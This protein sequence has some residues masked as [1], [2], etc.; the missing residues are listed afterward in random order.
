MA[1]SPKP[2]ILVIDD[3]PDEAHPLQIEVAK[4]ARLQVV[5]P[6]ELT[7]ELIQ[8]ANLV[9]VDFR[10]EDWQ[11]RENVGSL[12]LKPMNGLALAAV[13]RS[14]LHGKNDVSPTAFSIYSAHLD[15]LSSRLPPEPRA[16][17]IAGAHD[18]EW[19]FSKASAS[20]DVPLSQQV[21]SLAK[22]VQRLPPNWPTDGQKLVE[23]E[24]R[25]LFNLPGRV[26]WASRAWEDV[27]DCYPPIHELSKWSHGL[28][29]LRWM[30][31]RILPYPCFLMDSHSLA[32]RLRV[33]HESLSNALGR[34]G[35][36]AKL[37]EPALY[38]GVL[39]D[40]RGLRWWKSGVEAV[41]REA[42]KDKSV[43]P[44]AFLSVLP[45]HGADRLDP[46]NMLEPVNCLD[47]D[48]RV[49]PSTFSADLAVRIQPDDWP[50][51]A[52]QAWTTIELAKEDASLRALV[53]AQ[54]RNRI[55]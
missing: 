16:H 47:S 9:L 31:H 3:H 10:L 22:A 2:R 48:F 11:E 49:L 50:P 29:I 43:D 46:I 30:L 7:L 24:V 39:C 12:A 14:H 37:M 15:D 1:Q 38:R 45:Q 55:D 5:H 35:R 21:V 19:A 4:D 54:D 36:L 25:D 23:N 40:F 8:D 41:I 27:Q 44:Q 42:T 6:E 33:T 26:R 53:V 28:A 34:R 52:S 13:L 17:A 20:G 51:Y 18:L 32:L